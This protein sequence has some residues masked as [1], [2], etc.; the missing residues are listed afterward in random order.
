MS[1]REPTGWWQAPAPPAAHENGDDD[2]VLPPLRDYEPIQPERRGWREIARKIW[3]PIAAAGAFLVK[4]GAILFKLKIFTVG[5]SLVLVAV[6]GYEAVFWILAATV[7]LAG[8][9]VLFTRE[10]AT[11]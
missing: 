3:A 8:L 1:E 9:T 10:P 6:G 7:F 11:E 4:F 5:A 2:F